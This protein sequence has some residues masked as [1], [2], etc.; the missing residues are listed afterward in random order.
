VAAV[1]QAALLPSAAVPAPDPLRSSTPWH[2][3]DSPA[4]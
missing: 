3:A 4:R 1:H 2:D